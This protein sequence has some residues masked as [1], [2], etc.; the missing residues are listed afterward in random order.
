MKLFLIPSLSA[1]IPEKPFLSQ[2]Q[3]EFLAAVSKNKENC[4]KSSQ[5]PTPSKTGR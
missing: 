1:K 2:K 5:C 4:I 3:E